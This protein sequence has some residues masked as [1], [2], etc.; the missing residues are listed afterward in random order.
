MHMHDGMCQAIITELMCGVLLFTYDGGFMAFQ[1]GAKGV[2]IIFHARSLT[3]YHEPII[4][5]A[6]NRITQAPSVSP[7]TLPPASSIPMVVFH[8]WEPPKRL[9]SPLPWVHWETNPFQGEPQDSPPVYET[10]PQPVLNQTIVPLGVPFQIPHLVCQGS[11]EWVEIHW[12]DERD[13]IR[14]G[15]DIDLMMHQLHPF[16]IIRV[17]RNCLLAQWSHSDN[18]L[19]ASLSHRDNSSV[20]HQHVSISVALYLAKQLNHGE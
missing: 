13:I 4:S 14:Q 18:T 7:R 3:H 11:I 10:Q 19:P 6:I 12:H 1:W 17:V 9:E 16:I 2:V 20:H 5:L 15:S 8:L